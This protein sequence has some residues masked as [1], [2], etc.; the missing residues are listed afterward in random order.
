MLA[1]YHIHTEFSDDSV[2]PL[3][4]VVKDSVRLQLREIC[5]TD[6][7][8]YGIKVDWDSRKEVLYRQGEPLA[9]VDYPRYVAEIERMQNL[10][11][12]KI[13]RQSGIP[14]L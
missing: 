13:P 2:Y 6:H 9:N 3:E 5:I 10:Y 14:R 8:D 11:G 12:E 7:V 1:D 4:D